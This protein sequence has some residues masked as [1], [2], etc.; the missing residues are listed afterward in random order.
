MGYLVEWHIPKGRFA[1]DILDT[2]PSGLRANVFEI[3]GCESNLIYAD[4][5]SRKELSFV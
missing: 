4:F 5:S 3:D 1:F 2:L